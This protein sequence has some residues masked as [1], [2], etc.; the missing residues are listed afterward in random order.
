MGAHPLSDEQCRESVE[1]LRLHG[2]QAKAAQALGISRPTFQNRI[3]AA[4]RRGLMGTDPVLPGFRIKEASVQTDADGNIEKRWIRQAEDRGEEFTVP[5]GHVVKG[6]SAYTDAEGR[7]IGQWVKTREGVDPK[8]FT[9]AIREAFAEYAGKAI[10]SPPPATSDAELLTLFPLADWHIGMFAWKGETGSN[11]DLDIAEEV[12]GRAMSDLVARTPQSNTTIVLGGGDLLHSDNQD[13]RTAKSGHALQVDGRWQKVL[14]TACRLLVQTVDMAL[15]R[16]QSVIVRILP[17]NHDEHSAV[18]VAY[19]LLAWYRN[20]P[21][22]TVDA[23]PSLF[24]WHRWG[25]VL[26]GSTHGHLTKLADMPQIMAHRRAQ[27]WGETRFR[28]VHGFH[29]H[30]SARIATEGGGVISEVHQTPI[31][32]DA[33]HFGSGFLSGRSV[34]AITYHKEFGEI[35]RARVAVIDA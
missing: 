14:M 1:A 35:S 20:E 13:N 30:H 33:W 24:F 29:L 34:Q 10:P 18:A 9:E 32:Q 4:A 19:F 11:W 23:D 27:D 22:V 31:P 16:H 12:I 3:Y 17:G 28:Y 6:V 21:R 26:L 7:V 25:K 5:A 2:S 8:S 15:A